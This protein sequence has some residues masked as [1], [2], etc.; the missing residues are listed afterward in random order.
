MTFEE[1]VKKLDPTVYRNLKTAVELGKWPDGR[2]V[3]E[4][5]RAICMEAVLYYE[6][7][8]GVAEAE[9]VGYIERSR[10]AEG[11]TC[12]SPSDVAPIRILN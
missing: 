6:N 1:V 9:R 11:S 4:E 7:A 10:K 12:S 8:N 2:A 5:Q 3:T